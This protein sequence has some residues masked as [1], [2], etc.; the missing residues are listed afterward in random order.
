MASTAS[1]P[2]A[3][4]DVGSLGESRTWILGGLVL[5]FFFGLMQAFFD[6]GSDGALLAASLTNLG[7]LTASSLLAVRHLRA[8]R[9]LAAAGFA[10]MAIFAVC[11]AVAGFSGAGADQIFVTLAVLH[12]PAQALIAS[13]DWGPMWARAAAALS[14]VVMAIYGYTHIFGDDPGGDPESPVL[15]AAW[16]LLLIAV[17]GWIMTVRE[18]S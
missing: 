17:V 2:A 7:G 11:E 16:V 8:G 4:T 6:S 14:G 10:G 15:I 5:V 1:S 9:E 12:L 3:R 13:Q 18:E